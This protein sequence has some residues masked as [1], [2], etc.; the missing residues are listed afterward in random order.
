MT[1]LRRARDPRD[2][3][4][5][6][7]ARGA[8]GVLC[9]ALALVAC[10]SER[11]LEPKEAPVTE[12]DH[13]AQKL[14]E[15]YASMLAKASGLTARGDTVQIGAHTLALAPKIDQVTDV[16]SGGVAAAVSVSCKLDGVALRAF[17]A[18]SVG[19]D[20]SREVALV[21]AA[22]EWTM[23]YGMPMVDALA[24]KPPKLA[25]GGYQIYAGPAGIRGSKPDGLETLDADFFRTVEPALATLFPSK[26]GLHALSI[27][28]VREPDGRV[29]GEF[30]VDGEVSEPLKKLAVQ[31]TWPTSASSYILKQYYVL[32]GE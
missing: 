31:M 32:R 19:I 9:A 16:P 27:T 13:A 26:S 23:Q 18:G 4:R 2:R 11:K 24:A 22:D 5:V 10:R 17:T 6:S 3:S 1:P 12:A 15:L 28:A 7:N 29:D 20:T 8:S 30:R 25:H 21:T 14:P